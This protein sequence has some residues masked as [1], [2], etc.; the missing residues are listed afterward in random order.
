MALGGKSDLIK[1]SASLDNF[2]LM[3]DNNSLFHYFA[4]DSE[5]IEDLHY[6]FKS[7]QQNESL[8]EKEKNIPLLILN[9]N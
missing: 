3:F 5:I 9:S 7:L 1:E 6:I 4:A 2:N 8:T